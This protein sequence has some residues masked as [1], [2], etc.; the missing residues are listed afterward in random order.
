MFSNR[1]PMFASRG[2]DTH[3]GVGVAH[4]VFRSRLYRDID[5]ML[6]WLEVERRGPRVIHHNDGISGMGCNR[7]CGDIFHVERV[8]ARGFDVDQPGVGSELASYPTA[9][10]RIIIAGSYATARQHRVDE[11]A[12]RPVYAVTDENVVPSAHKGLYR[13][14][15]S[16]QARRRDHPT[17][18]SLQAAL[19][20][21]HGPTDG[22]SFSA[23]PQR[24]YSGLKSLLATLHVSHVA[25][26]DG[27][28][29]VYGRINESSLCM[30]INDSVSHKRLRARCARIFGTFYSWRRSELP[31]HLWMLLALGE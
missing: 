13:R 22:R 17:F 28:C 2:D 21:S 11:M 30:R 20:L 10:Q 12:C 1:V 14:D 29:A 23:V 7:N 8:R 18:A 16:H 5:T 15:A 26:H 24:V 9:D 27:G 3:R 31:V 25:E 6:E 19:S 4:N